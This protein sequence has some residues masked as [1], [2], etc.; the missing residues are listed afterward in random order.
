[1]PSRL[2]SKLIWILTS[3]LAMP[4]LAQLNPKAATPPAAELKPKTVGLHG[5]KLTDN[6][7]WLREKENPKVID[8]LKAENAYTE[9]VMG[10]FKK[11]EDSL[12][13]EMLGRIKQT[14]DTPPYPQRGYFLYSRTEE[15]KQYPILCRKH[16]SVGAVEEVFLD[17]NKLAEGQKFMTLG[18]VDWSDDNQ[19]L[20]YST[21]TDGHRDYDFH[22]KNF[23]SGEEIKTPI[24]KVADFVWAADNKTIFFITEDKAKRSYR[25]Y[26]YTLGDQESKLIYE[27]KDELFQIAVGRSSDR[28]AIFLVSGSSRTSDAR[29]L[30]ADQPKGEFKLLAKRRD[31]IKYSPDLRDGVFYIRTN[32]GAKEFKIVTA[33]L[34]KPEVESWKPFL[35]EQPGVKISSHQTFKDFLLLVERDKGLPQFRIYDFKTKQSHRITFPEPSYQAGEA[36]N[37]EFDTA[38][39]RFRYQSP[40]TPPSTFDYDMAKQ[41]RALIKQQEVL[42]GYDA[43]KYVVE[44]IS[45]KAKDG[46]EIPITVVRKK[47]LALDG[48]APGWLYGYGSY[49][50]PMDATFS[51]SRISLLDRGLVYAIGHI[52]G[53]GELGETW[54][55]QAR[56]MTKM[57]TFTDFI[58]CADHLVEK[59][60]IS[61]DKLVIEGGSTGGLLIGATLNLRPDLCKAAVLAVPFVDVL[62]TMSD[63]TLPL[64]TGEYIEW[65][66]PNKK[67]EYFYMKTYSP[68]D[69]LAA[70]NYPAMLLLTSLNDS[71]VPYWEPAKY[72]AKLRTLRTDA[73]PMIFKINLEAGHGGAS[74][75]YDRLK[76]I[77][78]EYTFGLAVLGLANDAPK[79]Q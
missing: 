52:R 12:Y 61:R 51:T 29:Y 2:T 16:G 39:F 18:H 7:F 77:A 13:A 65:G 3:L 5:D 41:S 47:D 48:K 53:G 73:N 60:Y 26:R 56:M 19:L 44:R 30:L 37:E 74:G 34:D 54:H 20:A 21:D 72:T 27:E 15:G 33:P 78:F 69:N 63:A 59:N 70:K 40:I 32:D 10:P 9:A 66:N 1:M 62:N 11:F 22:L 49:G 75:R 14:D 46:T 25:C 50:I 76:E 28:K 58:A 31:E 35:P 67:D 8:Y 17:V 6:Y 45:A 55:D 68:Y 42:G 4:A 64:T 71:Q 23:A 43:S 24:G 57:N 36:Q 38:Q 79:L